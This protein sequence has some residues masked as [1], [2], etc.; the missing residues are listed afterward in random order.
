MEEERA[1]RKPTRLHSYDYG[2]TGAYFV[3]VC[4]QDRRKI[5]S[6]IVCDYPT[7]TN[8][9]QIFNSV[10]EGLAPPA[11]RDN[12]NFAT[13]TNVICEFKSVGDGA[14]DVP[15]T[16]LTSIG[17]IVE[18]HLLSSAQI[19]GVEISDYVIMPDHIHAII[20]IKDSFNG[21][22]KAPSP[23]AANEALPHIVSTFKRFC[24][25]EIGKNIFQRSYYDHVIRDKRDFETRQKYIYENP[26][27]WY[28]DNICEDE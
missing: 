26:I 24:N 4:V 14:L 12:N 10:G 13:D 7:A 2:T 5:L 22:S 23:A 21:T 11:K 20:F 18:K 8:D 3:T 27:K 9:A 1:K 16:R 25:K 6:E 15:H 17:E 19:P 28:Y